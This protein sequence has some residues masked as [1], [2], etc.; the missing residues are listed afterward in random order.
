MK[1]AKKELEKNNVEKAIEILDPLYDFN[2]IFQRNELEAVAHKLF[3]VIGIQL[4]VE[5]YYADSWERGATL[6][7]IDNNVSDKAF[8]LE[9]LKYALKLNSP[10]REAFVKRLLN[11]NKTETDEVYYSV[12]LHGLNT[13]GVRQTGEFYM[14]IQGDRPYT[15]ETPLPMSMTKVFDHFTFRANFGGFKSNCD[16]ILTIAYKSDN[17][18]E[19]KEHR[20]TVNGNILY[21]G[22]QY[23]GEKNP[24]F[25]NELLAPGFESASYLLKS[26]IFING[27][28]ELEISEPHAGF[29]FCELW[30]K[31]A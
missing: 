12:A 11:R 6:E 29:K 18:P 20:I 30:I 31:K 4:D 8:F 25:D 21:E 3:K 16:Y 2:Y 27:T 10:E 28:L 5:H 15:K 23:G 13:L 9:K 14:D 24:D 26:D 7:T 17:N 1:Q 22:P 19:I